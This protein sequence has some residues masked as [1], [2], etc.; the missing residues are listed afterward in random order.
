MHIGWSSAI[1]WA[2]VA[3]I[4]AAA[5]VPVSVMALIAARRGTQHARRSADAAE[6]A[7]DA[8]ERANALAEK[9]AVRHVPPWRLEA[10]SKG[11]CVL[12]HVGAEDALEVRIGGPVTGVLEH[13]RLSPGATIP[14][15]DA[16]SI[17][18]VH[19]ITISWRHPSEYIL[20]TWRSG[21]PS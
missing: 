2:A 14:L 18:D 19:G 15:F 10:V 1:L 20:R 11:R 13:D 12:R 9:H 3:A 17:A 5:A 7:A 6:R 21:F 8:A 4:A 16:R